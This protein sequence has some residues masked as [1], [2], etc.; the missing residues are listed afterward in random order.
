MASANDMFQKVGRATATTLSAPGY[1]TGDS[2]VNIG[3]TTNW[4]TDTGV[5]FAIDVVDAAGERIAGTYNVFRGRVA[6]ASQV[7][8]VVYEGGDAHRSYPSGA[9]TRV[10]ILVSSYRDNRMVDGLMISHNQD[11]T[12]KGPSVATALTGQT[13]PAD[14]VTT[15][16]ITDASVTPAKWTNPYSFKAIVTTTYNTTPVAMTK[17][18]FNTKSYDYNTNFST[19]TSAYT[20]PVAGVYR[21]NANFQTGGSPSGRMFLTF[22]K[23]GTEIQR[24][25]DGSFT[26]YSNSIA[27]DFLLAA[28][29]TMTVYYYVGDTIPV[30]AT[31]ESVS[32]SGSLVHKV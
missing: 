23:N 17:L 26:A 22:Y 6:G 13:L 15:P 4:P 12:I 29:D 11:G 21:F 31:A 30:K 19:S 14:T 28:S 32:F 27:G 18:T 2:S 16:A 8:Q 9:T 3:S 20:A 7:D 24:G 25:P 10:Y 1:T 5:T